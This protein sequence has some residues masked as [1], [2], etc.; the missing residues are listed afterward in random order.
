MASMVGP[1]SGSD[2]WIS[3][4]S[5]S[6]ADSEGFHPSWKNAGG[7][8]LGTCP[9][10]SDKSQTVAR[11]AQGEIVTSEC[12]I[13]RQ[14]G[15]PRVFNGLS[16]ADQVLDGA[17]FS[18]SL[19]QGCTFRAALLRMADFSKSTA[20]EVTFIHADLTFADFSSGQF[21]DIDFSLADMCKANFQFSLLQGANFAK[22]DL[23]QASFRGADIRGAN[24]SDAD[25]RAADFAG[26]VFDD[27][28]VLQFTAKVA[29]KL[30]M[31]YRVR[32]PSHDLR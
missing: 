16:F 4:Q 22:A 28:T 3:I 7:E 8:L 17:D 10:A 30:G 27:S 18:A 9:F 15:E 32:R 2:S 31:K 6:L 12:F 29:Q 5:G 24:F 13:I 11:D 26:A 19:L 14:A 1:D 20:R 21:I 23:E 25:L